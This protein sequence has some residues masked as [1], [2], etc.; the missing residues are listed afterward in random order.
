[1]HKTIKLDD[2]TRKFM[3]PNDGTW[4]AIT[5]EQF[6]GEAEMACPHPACGW[7]GT[8]NLAGEESAARAAQLK[9]AP[10][11]KDHF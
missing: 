11:T 7:K 3:C 2:G 10:T 1:M 9:D 4:A 8:L 6:R 5:E